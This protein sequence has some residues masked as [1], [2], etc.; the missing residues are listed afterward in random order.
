MSLI[1]YFLQQVTSFPLQFTDLERMS[2]LL[3][4]VLYLI[5][6]LVKNLK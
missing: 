2:I 4:I 6:I 3:E 1:H 5:N